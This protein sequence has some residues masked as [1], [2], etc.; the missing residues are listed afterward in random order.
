MQIRYLRG[1][2][3]ALN[4]LNLPAG[5]IAIDTE[6]DAIRFYDGET[7][8]GFEVQ[9]QLV[10]N[11][12]PG[13]KTL[14]A[15]TYQAGFFG[16]V[17]EEDFLS[18]SQFIQDVGLSAGQLSADPVV[19]LKFA[20]QGRV[21]YIA[22]KPIVLDVSYTDLY[23]AGLVYG[24]DDFGVDP[25]TSQVSQFSPLI[26]GGEGFSVR[27]MSGGATN[28][29]SESGGEWDAL[30]YHVAANGP[31]SA[32]WAE[33]SDSDLGLG[34]GQW[35]QETSSSNDTQRIARGHSGITGFQSVDVNTQLQFRP[36][37]ELISVNRVLFPLEDVH[38]TTDYV[39]PFNVYHWWYSDAIIET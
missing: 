22:K 21:L 12:G 2:T 38:Y 16:E 15:G 34:V 14:V 32:G 36:V 7:L 18:G 4:R 3:A 13:P 26:V 6:R 27:L 28:P 9:G 8:G 1:T 37:L 24:V 10:F 30:L 33:Y 5:R 11:V 35:V 39:E 17:L 29:A 23:Q 25:L 31:D 20:Y 19:W